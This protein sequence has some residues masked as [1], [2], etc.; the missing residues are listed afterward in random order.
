ME[1]VN[2]AKALTSISSSQD[3]KGGFE[4][5]TLSDPDLKIILLGDSAVGK[6]KLIERYLMDEYNPRQVRTYT[7]SMSRRNT[8]TGC[9]CFVRLLV[10]VHLCFNSLQERNQVEG[11]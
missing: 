7:T 1:I 5:D 8:V 6:S 9:S 2:D 4:S 11:R 3:N 10:A